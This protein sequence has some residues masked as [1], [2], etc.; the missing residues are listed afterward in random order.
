MTLTIALS[1]YIH[2]IYIAKSKPN[3]RLCSMKNNYCF[4]CHLPIQNGANFTK[5][6]SVLCLQMKHVFCLQKLYCSR[7]CKSGASTINVCVSDEDKNIPSN[8]QCGII[9]N[10]DI[11]G[12]GFFGVNCDIIN[13]TVFP[14][15]SEFSVNTS[16]TPSINCGPNY[17]SSLIKNDNIQFLFDDVLQNAFAT[18]HTMKVKCGPI[19]QSSLCNF[20]NVLSAV[21]FS[22]FITECWA[23]LS[24]NQNTHHNTNYLN[25]ADTEVNEAE[26][27][28]IH[29][30]NDVS[31]KDILVNMQKEIEL[32]KTENNLFK[33]KLTEI[34]NHV[35]NMTEH[36]NES[37]FF[38]SETFA[39]FDDNL[40]RVKENG[41]KTHGDVIELNKQIHSLTTFIQKYCKN[42]YRKEEILGKFDLNDNIHNNTEQQKN[43][44]NV[45]KSGY[46]G[47]NAK[48]QTITNNVDKI[49]YVGNLPKN[50]SDSSLY[51]FFNEFGLI[52]NIFI[53]NVRHFAFIQFDDIY[54]VSAAIK[55]MDGFEFNK[56]TLI[57][58]ISKLQ[59]MPQPS[60][61]QERLNSIV[62]KYNQN[63]STE[64][65][66]K[67]R[68]RKLY[69][70]RTHINSLNYQFKSENPQNLRSSQNQLRTSHSNQIQKCNTN[71]R[72]APMRYVK[73]QHPHHPVHY[74]SQS[75]SFNYQNHQSHNQY[76]NLNNQS[77]LQNPINPRQSLSHN[78]QLV[79]QAPINSQQ[80]L[81]LN[82][83]LVLQAPHSHQHIGQTSNL[84]CQPFNQIY[85]AH[86][87]QGQILNH[88]YQSPLQSN[89]IQIPQSRFSNLNVQ[90]FN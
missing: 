53:N 33:N 45:E 56:R 89:F 51:N 28:E 19:D 6:L 69:Q 65:Y 38:M 74:R 43:A 70:K 79:L 48:Q 25:A 47:N 15:K 4:V 39:D 37:V 7:K 57:C 63:F 42:E 13:N 26:I 80:S 66:Q 73:E 84:N 9:D 22:V 12:N 17:Q 90:H 54:G 59:I 72:A 86:P 36:V 2:Y 41:L 32:L 62:P 40:G 50:T 64:R 30:T 21:L 87:P 52:K 81:N 85:R 67:K 78:N 77:L 10:I 34:N 46:V 88:N 11:I 24:M 27:I 18:I 60:S 76:S 5:C 44:N 20:D 35:I 23:W 3:R 71:F 75:R 82:N 58:E 14:F 83:Q 1:L 31:E 16:A 49:L 68:Q 55:K 29:E 8:A 61:R